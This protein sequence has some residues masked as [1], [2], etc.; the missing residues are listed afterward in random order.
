MATVGSSEKIS[1]GPKKSKRWEQ[2]MLQS[3]QSRRRMLAMLPSAA[4][5][6][7]L[8]LTGL[9]LVRFTPVRNQ[10]AITFSDHSA[11]AMGH[12]LRNIVPIEISQKGVRG[13]IG[14]F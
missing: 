13:G 8:G 5:L 7:L 1:S 11:S 10:T 6:S 2:T 9:H 12:E 3:R 4:G 14:K